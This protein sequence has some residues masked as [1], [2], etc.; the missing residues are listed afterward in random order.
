MSESVRSHGLGGVTALH[1]ALARLNGWPALGSAALFGAFSALAYAPFHLFPCL[2]ISFTALIWMLDGARGQRYWAR[3]MF[4]RGWAFGFGF[5]LISMF[6]TAQPFLVEPEKH[7]AFLWMPLIALPGGLALIWGATC[8]LA[9]A[10]WSSSP[11]RVFVFALFFALAEF[12]RG[13]LF[14]GFPW[15]IPGTTWAPG[16]PLSQLAAIGG[17]YWLSMVTVFV[18]S[19]PAALA[20]TRDTRG[21]LLRFSPAILAAAIL[22]GG[23]TWG[24]Q[25]LSA[26]AV[27]SDYTVVLMDA[28]VPQAE[29]FDRDGEPVL[30]RYA[31]LLRDVPS[32]PGDIVIWPEGAMPFDLL[33]SNTALDIISAFLDRRSLIVG[34]ARRGG[35]AGSPVFYNSL[36]IFKSGPNTA[37]MVALY[38]KHRLVPFG[39][40]AAIHIVPFGEQI[41]GI[42]PGAVQRIAESGFRPGLEP[43]V[44][45]P[46]DIMPPVIP[47]I[48]YEGLYPEL[49]R[50][51]VPQRE[52]AE[53]IVVI[54]NDA[55]FGALS[56]PAQHYAQNRYRAIESGLPMARVASRGITAVVDPFGREIARGNPVQGDPSGWRSSVVRSPLPVPT[57]TPM[58]QRLGPAVYW[59]SLVLLSLFSFLSWRR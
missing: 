24:L 59:L 29:K 9:G 51:A 35:Q 30:V 33:Q 34:T 1:E 3:A 11:S 5:F 36:A 15:N 53:W 56:G 41:A 13:V 14:G 40:L 39:E 38:D 21:M 23:W 57:N 26:D 58:Y 45:L 17:V 20:D 42:L 8:A 22:G 32:E 19:T 12:V 28:G 46:E 6:W 52:L 44:L 47:L 27:M 25:R 16:G 49:V 55:W 43:R 7:A 54:S 10:F 48:C 4:A 2:A 37:E 18:M 31:N 50:K